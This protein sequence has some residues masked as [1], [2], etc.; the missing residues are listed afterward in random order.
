MIKN[1]TDCLIKSLGN[2]AKEYNCHIFLWNFKQLY[3]YCLGNRIST[4]GATTLKENG[5]KQDNQ[6][7]TAV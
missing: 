3:S 5:Q 1:M 6:V 7:G 4:K 2:V